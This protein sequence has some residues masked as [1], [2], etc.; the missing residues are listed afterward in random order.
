MSLSEKLHFSAY[1]VGHSSSLKTH[2]YSGKL[3][4]LLQ[5]AAG[6]SGQSFL[7]VGG[8]PKKTRWQHFYSPARNPTAL[9][10]LSQI[11]LVNQSLRELQQSGRDSNFFHL[12]WNVAFQV[13]KSLNTNYLL[14]VFDRFPVRRASRGGKRF[15]ESNGN[16]RRL[17]RLHPF[18]P[19]TI[20]NDCNGL[21][22]GFTDRKNHRYTHHT[23][24]THRLVGETHDRHP[25]PPK[26][27]LPDSFNATVWSHTPI[28]ERRDAK[29]RNTSWTSLS[30][31]WI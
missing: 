5:W 28:M 6:V 22:L 16:T 4:Q 2:P 12:C 27:F 18:S 3:A 20:Q 30:I 21:L 19:E 1:L 14:F 8:I 11:N 29:Y 9:Q 17:P 31:T 7:D 25:E 13:P 15:G 24:T 10:R 26:G 23:P